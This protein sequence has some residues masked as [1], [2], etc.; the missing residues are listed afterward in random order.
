M[1]ALP[2]D[3][4]TALLTAGAGAI[5]G[6]LHFHSLQ[7]VVRGLIAGRL[8]VVALQILR[9]AVLALFLGFCAWISAAALLSAAAGLLVGRGVALRQV[10][11]AAS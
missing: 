2:F 8:R 10:Q 4:G 6:W 5:A 11:R 3:P 1:S 7:R 9:F